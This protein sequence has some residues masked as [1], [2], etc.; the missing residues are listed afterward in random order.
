M[1]ITIP[2]SEKRLHSLFSM[3]RN[4]NRACETTAYLLCEFTRKERAGRPRDLN[5]VDLEC[6]RELIAQLKTR[7]LRKTSSLFAGLYHDTSLSTIFRRMREPKEKGG[8]GLSRKIQTRINRNADPEAQV[9]FMESIAHVAS[10][11][12]VS[13]DG[14]VQSKQDF[15]DSYA[16]E[17]RG[18]P[19]IYDQIVIHDKSFAV[20]A[21]ATE[22]GVLTWQ[23]YHHSFKVTALAVEQFILDKV[24]PYLTAEDSVCI[25]DNASN[26]STDGVHTALGEAFGG[27]DYWFHIPAYS[28]RLAPIERVFALVKNYIRENESRGEFD[29]E[30]LIDEAFEYYSFRGAGGA[31]V[32]GFFDGYSNNH[33]Q[34]LAEQAA[35]LIV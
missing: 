33:R 24:Q 2:L 35:N 13:I 28:P 5:A 19:A 8:L 31:S 27:D 18:R 15:R 3:F 29:P 12:L 21:A 30:G 14:M 20:M 34:W 16:W 32:Y 4:P 7:R 6:L 25:L 17:E 23:R 11:R 9:A 10:S 1:V 22:G 26:Q